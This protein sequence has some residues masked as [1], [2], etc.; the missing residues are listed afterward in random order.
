M[1]FGE[2]SVWGLHRDRDLQGPA[3]TP[4]LT[5]SLPVLI[6]FACFECSVRHSGHY[7]GQWSITQQLCSFHAQSNLQHKPA[8]YTSSST[9]VLVQH[10]FAFT[11]RIKTNCPG[12]CCPDLHI[13]KSALKIRQECSLSPLLQTIASPTLRLHTELNI[14]QDQFSFNV[15]IFNMIKQCYLNTGEPPGTYRTYKHVLPVLN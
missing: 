3:F 15:L 13:E 8:K 1:D 10:W 5:I 9:Q 6:F 14:L 7:C 11:C 2:K 4:H 12:C